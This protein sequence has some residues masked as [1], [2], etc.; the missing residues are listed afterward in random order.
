M[1]HTVYMYIHVLYN[2]CNNGKL[3]HEL[4]IM[5]NC[6]YITCKCI[7]VH[8]ML[9]I[10]IHVMLHIHVYIIYTCNVTCTLCT[11]IMMI[12]ALKHTQ[13]ENKYFMSKIQ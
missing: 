7:T 10:H 4:H 13:N 12:Q 3:S 2:T 1:L 11:F 9:H 6:M 8:V 5:A